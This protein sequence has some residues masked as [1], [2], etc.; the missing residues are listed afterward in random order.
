MA[1][2]LILEAPRR[3]G[4]RPEADAPLKPG[5]VRLRTLLSGVSV[6]TELTYYRGT[7]PYLSKRWDEQQRLFLPSETGTIAYPVTN[8]GYEE[9]GEVVEVGPGVT[10]VP[11][12][13]HVFGTWGHRTHHVA[14]LD[15]VKLRLMPEGADPICGIFSHLGAIALNGVHDAAI[16]LGDTVAVF[17]LGGVGQEVAIMARRSGARVIG[18]DLNPARR[19]LALRL[20]AERAIDPEHENPA[21]AIKAITAGRGADVC[22]EV[23]GAGAALHEAIRSAGYSG[24]VVTMGFMQGEARGLFLG[25]EFHH[26]RINLVCSQISGVAPERSYQWSKPRLWRAAV[27]LQVA[28]EID[29]RPIVTHRLPFFEAADL[30]AQLDRNPQ[31][32]IQ[33]VLEF[34]R[35][36]RSQIR[37]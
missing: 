3:I 27:E 25:E 31:D 9:V 1:T 36:E 35:E 37:P 30:Y 20:G 5:E 18:V 26:N 14:P 28:G 11:V 34:P 33:A 8:L 2:Q 17:G 16:K 6:G 10:E 15:Y 23:S 21:L 7:N 24:R 4:F 29:L 32:V 22:I 19:A 13:A 12:G